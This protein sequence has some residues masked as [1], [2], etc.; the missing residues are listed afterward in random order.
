[1]DSLPIKALLDFLG[2][3]VS[4]EQLVDALYVVRAPRH[5]VGIIPA[6]RQFRD[7]RR[8]YRPLAEF[9]ELSS[10]PESLA[11]LDRIADFDTMDDQLSGRATERYENV[12]TPLRPLTGDS[13]ICE[14]L[15]IQ[16]GGEV[17]SGDFERA[18]AW[19]LW[20]AQRFHQHLISRAVYAR[21][22]LSSKE[23]LLDWRF[24]SRLYGAYLALRRLAVG[25]PEIRAQ[26]KTLLNLAGEFSDEQSRNLTLLVR[27]AR[28]SGGSTGLAR[29]H[30]HALNTM[31]LNAAQ[32][33]EAVECVK[34]TVSRDL[35]RLLVTIWDSSLNRQIGL[36]VSPAR[37][38][39]TRSINRPQI[40]RGER[41]TE[42]R[43]AADEEDVHSG[44]VV[45]FFP[46]EGSLTGRPRKRDPD[47]DDD[48]PDESPEQ[49]GFSIF[50]ADGDDLL[51]GYYAAKGIQSAIEYDNAQLHWDKWTLS[52][53]GVQA[54]VDLVTGDGSG[55]P[56][57]CE[58]RLAMGLSLLTGRSLEEV[59]R[60]PIEEQVAQLPPV[61]SV[62]I[63]RFRLCLV[64]RA[65]QP[66]LRQPPKALQPFCR[67]RSEML[68][69]PLPPAWRG[70]VHA[71]RDPRPRS[72][73]AIT[74]RARQLLGS[75][76]PDLR[77]TAKG[78]RSALV[79]A[80]NEQTQGDL[81]AR[82][83]GDGRR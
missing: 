44:T 43:L 13:V 78:L 25:D 22:L 24:G 62:V 7:W 41:L 77:V 82:R 76:A 29:L 65:G 47:D 72:L 52:Q 4:Q 28:L 42:I 5:L 35:A 51:K 50:L 30:R 9:P 19:L 66:E 6:M 37:G 10:Y 21:Y 79:R 33:E 11:I 81:G 71:I 2:P 58:A 32:L 20:Q 49:P 48:D 15:L 31:G 45:E 69:L 83:G 57:D 17:D 60:P 59:V 73:K 39:T 27:L 64:V 63:D 74:A 40:R 70:L 53:V 23:R 56:L 61:V 18:S 8:I 68:V 12:W 80:L 14:L 3:E 26:L 55:T 54:V 16:A 1:M 38:L 36:R 75:L 67:P 46:R 34:R